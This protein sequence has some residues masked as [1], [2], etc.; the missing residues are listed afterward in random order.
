MAGRVSGIKTS[1]FLTLLGGVDQFHRDPA[2]FPKNR[3]RD[4]NNVWAKNNTL[5]KRPGVRP[6]GSLTFDDTFDGAHEYIDAAGTAHLLVA[7]NAKVWEVT[8][9]TRTE[10]FST[11]RERISFTTFRGRC[12]AHGASQQ[13]KII[14]STV[15][16]NGLAAP[17]TTPTPAAGVAGALTGSYAV[18]VTYVIEESGVRVWESDPSDASSSVTLSSEQLSLSAVPVSSDTRVNARYIYR[19]TAGG[20]KYYYDGKISDNTTTTYTSNVLDAALGDE[21]EY[22]HGQMTTAPYAEGANERMF[23]LVGNLLYYSEIGRTDSYIEYVPATNFYTLPGRGSPIGL[24]RL[25]NKGTGREDLFIFQS[26]CVSMLPSAD[27]NAALYIID[28]NVGAVSQAS[29]KEYKGS[30]VFL[31]SRNTVEMIV[32]GQLVDIS[33]RSIPTD[34]EA[35]LNKGSASAELIYNRFYALCVQKDAGKLYNHV[36]WV[37]DLSTVRV[38]DNVE[39]RADAVWYPWTID[40]NYIVARADG[41]YLAFDSN[42][43]KI[44]QISEAYP[45]DQ[46]AAGT[47]VQ[48]NGMA[49]GALLMGDSLNIQKRPI[50]MML[51]GK[52]QRQINITPYAYDARLKTESEYN[53]V[54]SAFIAGQSVMGTATTLVK[55]LQEAGIDPYTVGN[56]ISFKFESRN[57][58]NL[59]KFDG[60]EFTYMINERLV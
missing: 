40:A 13:R 44:F 8:S 19:T 16:E 30:L 3:C 28:A 32:G 42:T 46:N 34:M 14:I 5:L 31:S 59:F 55:D 18:R 52:F 49:W 47:T 54:E 11:E 50:V 45:T 20:A 37:C 2:K 41:T 15:S 33:S 38:V 39:S 35:L 25:Y 26:D 29:I 48:I 22:T 17:A 53:P 57:E 4:A 58:D 21:V 51:R 43:K 24:K 60:Y 12:F 56:A 9:S 27:P 36:V 23:Y 1:G 7:S 6:W 10:L